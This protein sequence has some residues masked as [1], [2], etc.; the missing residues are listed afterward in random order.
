MSL[1]LENSVLFQR[2]ADGRPLSPIA[3]APV[4]KDQQVTQQKDII[5]VS[6]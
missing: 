5:Q 3:V 6:K 4:P 1:C 2:K